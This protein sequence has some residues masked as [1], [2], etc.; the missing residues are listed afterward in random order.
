MEKEEEEGGTRGNISPKQ[1]KVL[2][3][4]VK[5]HAEQIKKIN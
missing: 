2:W 5:R 4:L 1:F 3:L